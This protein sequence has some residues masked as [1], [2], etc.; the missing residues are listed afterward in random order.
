VLV[1]ALDLVKQVRD[2]F[3]DCPT[4]RR[5][6][7]A[8]RWHVIPVFNGPGRWRQYTQVA[9]ERDHTPGRGRFLLHH[10]SRLI[11]GD[12]DALLLQRR[13]DDRRYVV[14]GLC[15]SRIGTD[16]KTALLRKLLAEG[17]SQQPPVPSS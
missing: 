11:A 6:I 4:S 9:A 15:S 8:G 2:P 16:A 7:L 13:N 5:E 17:C 10:T 3:D 14:A 1:A 12:I